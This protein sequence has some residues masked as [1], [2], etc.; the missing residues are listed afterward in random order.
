MGG[1]ISD[2]LDLA[3]VIVNYNT[4]SLLRD[5]LQSVYAGQGQLSM[6][7]CVVDNASPDDS[8]ARVRAEFPQV[9]VIANGDNAGYPQA[10][11]QALRLFGFGVFGDGLSARSPES[12]PRY[13][14]LLNPDTVLPPNALGDMV[15]FLDDRPGAG[16]AGPKLVRLDGS[17]DSACRRS[18]PTPSTSLWHMLLLDRLFPHSRRF[19]RYNLTYL[20]PDM[21][22]R[23]DALV[24]A[25]MLVRRE[26]I[27][28]VGL[29]DETFWMYGEDL[30]W[31][32]R[33]QDCGWEIWYNPAVTVTH[34]KEAASRHSF[35]AR[36]E[37]YRA[38]ILF[39]EKHYRA[40]TPLWLDWSI[41][42]GVRVFGSLDLLSWRLRGALAAR[43]KTA[44]TGAVLPEARP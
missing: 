13:A 37:F 22:S 26:A 44:T 36:R 24:G 12:L 25:F 30:D 23:V 11:N 27:L 4:S 38:L 10:N 6:A 2:P 33:I 5:C 14:L 40:T 32:K 3:I 21:L 17:L 7:V 31:A 28:A 43:S 35:R 34:I 16:A 39:Y 20:D 18:F 41:R 19:G 9:R 42:A 1:V 15:A 29:L 8:V